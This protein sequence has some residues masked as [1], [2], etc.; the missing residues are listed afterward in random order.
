[1]R[2]LIACSLAGILAVA[3]SVL[4]GAGAASAHGDGC[5]SVTR[6]G[7]APLYGIGGVDM[8]QAT[9]WSNCNTHTHPRTM[10]FTLYLSGDEE[11]DW[12]S[13]Y[14]DDYLYYSCKVRTDGRVADT[15]SGY[16]SYNDRSDAHSV[17][18][19]SRMLYPY[20]PRTTCTGKVV[21]D[22]EGD[23]DFSFSERAL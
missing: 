16:L 23:A 7:G 5:H 21:R 11:Q 3:G 12:A 14:P 17:D 6:T 9:V 4:V 19:Q 1:M 18:D 22:W 13:G 2:K 10:T 20:H 15:W 8:K